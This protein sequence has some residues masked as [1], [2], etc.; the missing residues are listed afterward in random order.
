MT[1]L[2]I[3]IVLLV[4]RFFDWSHVRHFFWYQAYDRFIARFKIESSNALL[5][6]KVIPLTLLIVLIDYLFQGLLYGLIHF[7]FS[8]LVVI[9]CLGPENFW[10]E[11]FMSMNALKNAKNKAAVEK[12]KVTMGFA[13]VH[14]KTELHHQFLSN[15]FVEANRRIFAMIFWY[16]VLGLGG[17]VLYRTV[18]LASKN[19]LSA[20][21]PDSLSAPLSHQANLIAGILDWVPVRIFTF[22]FALG[23]HFT[24]VI[25]IWRK[26]V[27]RDIYYNETLLAE[28]GLAALSDHT[29]HDQKTE[30]ALE[31]SAIGLID[32]VLV[33]TLV[34]IALY[35]L[36]S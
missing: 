12:L 35:V 15:I 21:H 3:L 6:L 10:A 33:I 1:F 34:I 22:L 11:A 7:L 2:V 5:A 23:G 8:L 26:F 30:N 17:V 16:C 18:I 20:D 31:N 28:C 25:T 29:D 13:Q 32:R 9:F 27:L 19:T 36:I 24:K 4:E 14:N